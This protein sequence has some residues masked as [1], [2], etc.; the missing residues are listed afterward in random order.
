MAPRR[1][2]TPSSSVAGLPARSREELRLQQRQHQ[3][4]EQ[5]QRNDAAVDIEEWHDRLLHPLAELQERPGEG[6]EPQAESHEKRVHQDD[7]DRSLHLELVALA[8][9]TALREAPASLV[10]RQC[11]TYSHR[12]SQ[13]R[14]RTNSRSSGTSPGYR[15]PG[16]EKDRCS[17]IGPR[18]SG[19]QATVARSRQAPT[20][21]GTGH[22]PS[23]SRVTDVANRSRSGCP[24]CAPMTSRRGRRLSTSSSRIS[25]GAADEPTV[26]TRWMT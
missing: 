12:A 13:L 4:H 20:K 10:G 1:R 11:S 23:T 3:V 24:R 8:V 25:A 5:P 6:E 17:T 19:R 16:P 22:E 14:N 26:C 9:K 2:R 7:H 21:I 15:A 18:A